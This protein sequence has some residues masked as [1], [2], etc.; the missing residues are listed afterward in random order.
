MSR[1]RIDQYV[2]VVQT[3]AARVVLFHAAV[4]EQLG[5]HVT[6]L[7]CLRLLG[8]GPMTAG[9]LSGLLGLT[10]AAGTALIDRLEE[11]GFVVRVRNNDDRRRVEVKAIPR[12]MRQIDALYDGQQRR[13]TRLLAKYAEPEFRIILDFLERTSA[14]LEE[15]AERLRSGES[16]GPK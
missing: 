10:T 9:A 12:R 1:K 8:D 5:I 3:F 11:A 15:E 6:D 16:A 2:P 14:V 4:A 13:M 7:K